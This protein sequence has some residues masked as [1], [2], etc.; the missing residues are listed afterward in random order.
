MYN[1][2]IKLLKNIILKNIRFYKLFISPLLGTNCRYLPT[3]SEYLYTSIEKKGILVGFYLGI[4]RLCKCNP[5]GGS[6]YD[7][8]EKK[9]LPK[10]V[11]RP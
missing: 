6:G 5:L 8:V 7:P 3:C 1:I 9:N 11:K 2:I 10:K 4:V